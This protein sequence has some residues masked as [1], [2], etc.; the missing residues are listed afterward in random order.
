MTSKRKTVSITLNDQDY[1]ALKALADQEDRYIS[2]QAR[3]MLRNNLA[4][5]QAERDMEGMQRYPHAE[6]R[7]ADTDMAG[8]GSQPD[9]PDPRL[10]VNPEPE[11]GPSEA[12]LASPG[13][14]RGMP[15]RQ[16]PIPG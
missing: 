3:H 1:D 11:E 2:A 12:E 5:R 7:L 9:P 16:G 6:A 13:R 4:L 8:A 15:A 10:P 14:A